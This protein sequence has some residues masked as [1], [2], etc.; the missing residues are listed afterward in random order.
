MEVM[1]ALAI[2]A[3]LLLGAHAILQQVGDAATHISGT[4]AEVDRDANAEWLLRGVVGRAEQPGPERAFTGTP[5]GARFHS[6]CDVP[7]GWQERCS[8][9]VGVL[10]MEDGPVLAVEVEGE[11]VAVRRGFAE[12]RVLYLRDAAEGGSWLPQ[13]NSDVAAPRALGVVMDADT[14]ILRVGERG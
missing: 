6:W 9:S 8:V 7:A 2:S 1:V 14:M 10:P 12:G 5:R 13:W 3:L 4:A 11:V